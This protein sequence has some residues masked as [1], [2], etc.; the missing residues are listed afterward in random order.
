MPC[1]AYCDHVHAAN[2]R[3]LNYQHDHN[4]FER[5]FLQDILIVEPRETPNMSLRVS[6]GQL[7]TWTKCSMQ[8]A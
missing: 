4:L 6:L 5:Q 3:V 8:N 2:L 7:A 1:N